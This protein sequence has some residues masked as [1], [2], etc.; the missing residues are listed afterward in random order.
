MKL[1]CPFRA[2]CGPMSYRSQARGAEES[3]QHVWLWGWG[4]GTQDQSGN[5]TPSVARPLQL[6]GPHDSGLRYGCFLSSDEW[7]TS[8]YPK[9][10][11]EGGPR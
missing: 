10:R 1:R 5:Q 6:P 7:I 11:R 2:A 3:E 8:A 9:I 4:E